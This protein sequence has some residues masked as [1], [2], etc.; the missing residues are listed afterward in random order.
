MY[1]TTEGSLMRMVMSD[2][3]P[4]FVFI[5]LMLICAAGAG[6]AEKP[7]YIV[8]PPNLDQP[9]KSGPIGRELQY[10]CL[11]QL[12]AD[13]RERLRFG[14]D[15]YLP[16]DFATMKPDRRRSE[17]DIRPFASLAFG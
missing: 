17:R 10:L 1:T 13:C 14:A 8:K 9:D 15:S 3:V 12:G 2:N 11:R 16:R 5:G 6:A 7:R 4:A